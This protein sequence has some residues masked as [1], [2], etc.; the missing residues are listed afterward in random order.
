MN[1]LSFIY[2]F[3]LY[4]NITLTPE[5]IGN[6]LKGAIVTKTVKALVGGWRLQSTKMLDIRTYLDVVEVRLP[7]NRRYTKTSTIPRYLKLRIGLVDVLRQLVDTDRI[8]ITTHERQTGDIISVTLYESID[9][10]RIQWH[11]DIIP[12][13]AAMAPWAMAWTVGD[14]DG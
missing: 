8:G 13:V 4:C 5:A 9:S 12:K 7:N 10:I 2:L 3:I 1:I 11:T 14:I 6:I